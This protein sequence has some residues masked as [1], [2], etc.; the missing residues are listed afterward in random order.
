MMM[1]EFSDYG[2][3]IVSKLSLGS[4]CRRSIINLPRLNL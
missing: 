2:A 4:I 3:A 1:L